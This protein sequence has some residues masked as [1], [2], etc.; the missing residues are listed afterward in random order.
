MCCGNQ[1]VMRGVLTLNCTEER[2]DFNWENNQVHVVSSSNYN[3]VIYYNLKKIQYSNLNFFFLWGRPTPLRRLWCRHW[4]KLI[5]IYAGC[6]VWMFT[7][8]VVNF[9]ISFWDKKKYID[10]HIFSFFVN[11]FTFQQYFLL[12]K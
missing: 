6:F 4:F 9:E 10:L 2:V 3:E 11:L 12:F 5:D 7:S 8:L 1:I